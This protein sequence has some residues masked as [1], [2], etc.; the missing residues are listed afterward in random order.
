MNFNEELDSELEK[1]KSAG[2]YREMKMVSGEPGRDI[3]VLGR[4]CLNFSSNNY[5]GLAA[6][7]AV[8][9][10]AAEALAKYGAGGTSSRL[11]A[12]TL[13]VHETLEQKLASHKRSGKALV[14]PSGY[15]ANAGIIAALVKEG[16]CVI[17]DRLNHASLWDGAKL[18]GARIF[19]YPHLDAEGLEKTLK[20]AKIYKRILVI[21]DSVFSMDGDIAPL[22][23]IVALSKRYGA[24]T[25]IDEAHST[26]ILGEHGR[27]LAE[28]AGV[29]GQVDIIMGTL[30]K[31]L[32]SQ[33]GFVCGSKE[34]I[35]YLV[36]KSRPF[37]Y[38]TALAPASGAA[39]LKALEI[40]EKEP[41]RRSRLNALSAALRGKLKALGIDT[42]A[43][44]TQ[45]IPAVFG[46]LEKTLTLSKILFDSGVFAPA[47]RPP[48]VPEG[49]CRLR[50]SL[51]SDHTREDIDK[52]INVIGGN[53]A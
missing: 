18:S 22:K 40:S 48:T 4:K 28:L 26:G 2:L 47:I 25:M 12:G 24:V 43:S 10:A 7:P 42:G 44:E 37:I 23:T 27:G 9:Q 11:V 15:Q 21:T 5:L 31:A 13:E 33:G 32:G 19:V 38:S 3:T 20:R 34:L 6:H 29:E 49:Q 35:G 16:D 14:Y 30:S 50:F 39:A 36:N 1:L 45:I 52:L 41:E 17:M 8:K 53:R 46:S 51:T